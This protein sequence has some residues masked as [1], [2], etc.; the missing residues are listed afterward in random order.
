MPEAEG[1]APGEQVRYAHAQ[2]LGEDFE[3]AEGDIPFAPLHRAD[4]GSVQPAIVRQLLLREPVPGTVIADI[5]GQDLAEL[6]G[7][8]AHQQQEPGSPAD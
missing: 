6:R 1:S 4:V 3:G 2:R 7:R 8:F 5:V